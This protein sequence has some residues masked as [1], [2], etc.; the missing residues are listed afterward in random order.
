MIPPVGTEIKGTAER[1]TEFLYIKVNEYSILLLTW[2][3]GGFSV[4]RRVPNKTVSRILHTAT[5]AQRWASTLAN[6]S[7]ARHRSNIRAPPPR[8]LPPDICFQ[9]V[10]ICAARGA[11]SDS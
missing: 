10:I 1:N 4:R 7:N 11:E 6:R 5:L 8:P 9:S 3:R 2:G